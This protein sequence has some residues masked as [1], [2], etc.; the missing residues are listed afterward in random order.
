MAP[1][2]LLQNPTVHDAH[3]LAKDTL[4]TCMVQI[5]GACTIDYQGRAQSTLASGER[6][7][8]LKPDGTLLV[9]TAEGVKPVNWQPPGT[10]T[11]VAIKSLDDDEPLLVLTVERTSP[12][13]IVTLAFEDVHFMATFHLEDWEDIQLLGTE[14]DIAE[15]LRL[16][17]DL[18]EAGFTPYDVE[19]DRRR[20]PMDI[21][22][23]DADDTRTVVEVKRRTAG[24]EEATQLARYV[25]REREKHGDVRG[26][27]AAPG[28]SEKAQHYLRDKNLEHCPL[29]L[30]ELLPMVPQLHATQRTLGA[31]RDTQ[32]APR[33]ASPPEQA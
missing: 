8:L 27:L 29:D 30:D 25:E 32:D 26:L 18:I 16:N 7:V 10:T 33:P 23:H 15:L 3:E 19:L 17:P 31:F 24:I 13:E 11:A 1:P 21:Y 9:H 2:Q 22:G 5:V 6:L 28:I 4:D 12:N 20:G 14:A